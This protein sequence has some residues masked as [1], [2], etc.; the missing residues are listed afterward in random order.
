MLHDSHIPDD[1]LLLAGDGELSNRRDSEIRTHLQHCWQCRTRW[2]EIEDTIADFTQ[3]HHRNFDSEASSAVA[4]RANLKAQLRQL[5]AQQPETVWNPLSRLKQSLFPPRRLAYIACTFLFALA[6]LVFW[7]SSQPS[8]ASNPDPA[9]TPGATLPVSQADLCT[10]KSAARPRLVLASVGQKV[11]EEY[12]IRNPKPGTY[13]LDYL[14]DADLGGSDDARNLW[15]QPYSAQWNAHVK[16]ALE[17]H[18][19][20]LVCAGKISL[21]QAQQDISLDWT[22]AYKKYFRT[23]RPLPAHLAFR[24]DRPWE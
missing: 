6:A 3:V 21:A 5:A 22:S 18:L 13:E 12:G 19:R 16:D 10:Q 17:N 7:Q 24:K 8:L 4:A 1:E 14:I 23:D 20:E 2:K 15:P 11:F 9:L